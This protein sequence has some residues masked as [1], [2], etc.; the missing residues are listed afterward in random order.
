MTDN[1]KLSV[2]STYREATRALLHIVGLWPLGHSNFFYRFLPFLYIFAVSVAIFATL[3]YVFHHITQVPLVVKGMGIGTSLITVMLKMSTMLIHR[4]RAR[5]LHQILEQSFRAALG[6]KRLTNLLLKGISTVRALCWIL[7]PTVFV[8][9]A[10][11][12][13]TPIWNIIL[14]KRNTETMTYQLIYPGVYPWDIP[15]VLIYRIHYTIET[16]ASI[17]IFSVT[18]GIDA[19]FAYY[20]FLMIGQLRMMTYKLTHLDDQK[21]IEVVVKECVIYSVLSS[22]G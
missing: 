3:N 13:V 4:E 6:D 17:T 1:T 8:M 22:C 18:C 15:N 16:F 21:R 2:Y 14:Q 19:L 5:D 9:M 12:T 20:I 7:I 10:V 11:Y